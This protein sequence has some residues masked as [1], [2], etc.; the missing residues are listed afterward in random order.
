ML[1]GSILA[2]LNAFGQTNTEPKQITSYVAD[3][4]GLPISTQQLRPFVQGLYGQ[5][6]PLDC[7]GT[8]LRSYFRRTWLV[9]FQTRVPNLDGE[10][11][12]PVLE[13]TGNAHP[14]QLLTAHCLV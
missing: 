9:R 13:A 14:A 3:S 7:E 6:P 4:I 1:S 10:S 12:E 8:S 2:M 11:K 5:L